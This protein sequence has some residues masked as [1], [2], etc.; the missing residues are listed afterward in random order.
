VDDGT[1]VPRDAVEGA[2]LGALVGDCL[3]APYEGHASV[4]R[5][6]AQRRIADAVRARPLRYTDD[7]QLMLA[8]A[9][10]LAADDA[11]VSPRGFA[12]RILER[13]EG[14]RGYGAGMHRLVALWRDGMSVDE[15][16]TAVFRD[17]SYGN[18]AAMRVAPVGL[19]WAH[20]A[21]AVIEV[22]ARSAGVTHAHAVGI[23]GATLQAQAVRLAAR[24]R[25]FTMAHLERLTARTDVLRAGLETARS[26]SS[27]VP[28]HE[29][30]RTLGSDAT[31]QRSVPAALWCAA[32]AGDHGEAMEL[33]LAVA[34]DTDTIATMAGAVR[35]A[36]DGASA[37][38][39]EWLDAVEGRDAVV[40]AAERMHRLALQL[41]T[42]PGDPR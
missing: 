27:D 4:D 17:G 2:M 31:A 18:G 23:D 14:W 42:G 36:A 16:R 34:G 33:A 41:A 39:G 15:A 26:L 7:T 9:E 8:L 20:D 11:H 28:P 5:A 38:P 22:A 12:E 30:A 29:V 13:Y 1:S 3:G 35:G 32:V 25:A 19:V 40:A 24:D 10:H 6:R 21:D 37:I